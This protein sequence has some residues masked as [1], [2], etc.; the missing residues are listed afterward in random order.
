M[1]EKTYEELLKDPDDRDLFSIDEWKDLVNKANSIIFKKFPKVV[2]KKEV[3]MEV[4]KVEEEEEAGANGRAKGRRGISK[5]KS[6]RR[7]AQTTDVV[8]VEHEEFLADHQN[9]VENALELA[10]GKFVKF[11]QYGLILTSISFVLQVL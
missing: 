8:I 6:T 9:T 11:F 1:W 10:G 7:K 3:D 4:D 5:P 2:E